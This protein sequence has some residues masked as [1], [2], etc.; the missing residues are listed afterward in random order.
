MTKQNFVSKHIRHLPP[1][2]VVLYRVQLKKKTGNG[3]L[4]KINC[5]TRPG[6]CLALTCRVEED[7]SDIYEEQQSSCDGVIIRRVF[8]RR[9]SSRNSLH[10]IR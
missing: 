6:T 4:G 8:S 10:S 5:S 1:T 3:Y 2:T 9:G 7:R